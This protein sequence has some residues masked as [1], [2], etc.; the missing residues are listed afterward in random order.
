LYVDKVINA[1]KE[2][3]KTLVHSEEANAVWVHIKSKQFHL[4]TYLCDIGFS[5]HHGLD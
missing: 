1:E 3:N 5:I 4:G 2:Y